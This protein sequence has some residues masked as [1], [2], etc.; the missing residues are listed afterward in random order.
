[1][2]NINK[3]IQDF[4]RTRVQLGALES[5]SQSLKVQ[6]SVLGEAVKELEETKEKKVYKA[7]G[8]ILI[9][10]NVSKVKKELS[11]QK[12]SLDL[13]VKTVKKQ[14]ET[15]LNKLNTLKSEIEDFQKGSKD[16]KKD[17][18]EK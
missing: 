5:Q 8:N 12:E 3:L 10:T 11:D 17:K 2:E 1:M 15:T 4:E 16:E 6:S 9:L 14:E 13:R 18:E 7:I